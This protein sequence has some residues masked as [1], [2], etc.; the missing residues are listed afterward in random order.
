M[1]S[2]LMVAGLVVSAL[3][4]GWLLAFAT[5]WMGWSAAGVRIQSEAQDALVPVEA[6]SVEPGRRPRSNLYVR[7]S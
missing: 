6:S 1:E 5:L 4:V 2:Q 7:G 3:F